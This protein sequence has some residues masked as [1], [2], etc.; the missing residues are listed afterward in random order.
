MPVD[1]NGVFFCFHTCNT[2]SNSELLK[3]NSKE[4]NLNLQIEFL[5]TISQNS[6]LY[7]V[8]SLYMYK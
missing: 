6:F 2:I 3:K 4:V 5:I 7:Y 1:V 8:F